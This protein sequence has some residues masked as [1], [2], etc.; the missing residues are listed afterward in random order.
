MRRGLA[1]GVI[2]CAI[3]VL[4]LAGRADAQPSS[5]FLDRDV[6]V[7]E[8][9]SCT[10]DQDIS[11][12]ELLHRGAE[13][14]QRGEV[15]Y[16]QGD[17]KGAVLELVA[18][19]CEIPYYTILKDI[20]QA[21]ERQL[22]YAKAIAYFERY[23][24]AVPA[25]AQKP[26]PCAPDPQEDKKNVAARIKILESLTAK[27]RVQT[28]PA[29][30]HIRIVQNDTTKIE[31]KSGDELE[32]LGGP[33]QLIIDRAGF[34]TVTREIHAEIG[35]PYTFF[36]QLQPLTGHVRVR[37][38]PG[39]ARV[40]LDQR[41]VGT[42]IYDATLPVGK[43]TL[44]AEAQGRTTVTRPLEVLADRDANVN[45]E[46]PAEPEFGRRQLMIYGGIGGA[47]AGALI[48]NGQSSELGAVLGGVAGLGAGLLGVYYGTPHDLALGTSSLTVTSSL[49]GGVAG[50]SLSAVITG[51][52]TGRT[53]V[54]APLIGS[55]LI[56]GAVAGYYVADQ[57]HPSPGDAAVIDSGAL[58]GTVAGGL[59]AVTLD[60]GSQISGGLVLSG[61]GMGTLGGVLL[62]RYTT[63]SRGHAALVDASGVAGVV[64]GLA[65][66]GLV[67]R[68]RD[69]ESQS[70]ARTADYAL[71]GLAAGLILGGILTRNMDAPKIAVVPVVGKGTLGFAGSW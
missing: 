15:L 13:H 3:G 51:N 57:T 43:Y 49:I 2:A 27:I 22:E 33:Y 1:F 62:Q 58:W 29:D 56:V 47:A 48:A 8:I 17:Y 69:D 31:G 42:G 39:D 23:V 7:L 6:Q 14:Y 60:T 67:Q 55:G 34:H 41:E 59:F 24:L 12:D 65:A 4:A 32:V 16:L 10:P 11:H 68:A 5:G 28:E 50:A 66:E 36:E 54:S 30:A 70:D 37:V 21:Y 53:G 26:N 19:Y 18:S 71:G 46:L 9:D 35:K 61:L 52:L 25:D 64:L 38:T 63:V 45:L 20:G 44:Q 40:F